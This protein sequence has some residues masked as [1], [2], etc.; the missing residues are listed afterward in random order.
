VL[1]GLPVLGGLRGSAQLPGRPELALLLPPPQRLLRLLIRL[2]GPMLLAGLAGG[3]RRQQSPRRCLPGSVW[4]PRPGRRPPAPR[5]P[6]GPGRLL[7]PEPALP[8]ANRPP[9]ADRRPGVI[10]LG[11]RTASQSRFPGPGRR[12]QPWADPRRRRS[13]AATAGGMTTAAITARAVSTPS[14]VWAV[15]SEARLTVTPLTGPVAPG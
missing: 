3:G 12:P 14:A 2:A 1:G 9:R 5:R 4:R 13:H 15:W 10:R 7:G 8:R 6:P 11:T